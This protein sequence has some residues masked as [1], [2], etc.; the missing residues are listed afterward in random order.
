MGVR[1]PFQGVGDRQR[2]TAAA[3]VRRTPASMVEDRQLTAFATIRS[4]G[5]V[6]VVVQ[7]RPPRLARI[8]AAAALAGAS[9]VSSSFA[10]IP[11]LSGA[12]AAMGLIGTRV[13]LA[14]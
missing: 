7:V 11:A 6:Q 1:R 13:R 8:A 12:T 14:P 4:T 2:R 3:G 10:G 5:G 9:G